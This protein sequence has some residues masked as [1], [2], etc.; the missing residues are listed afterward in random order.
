[1]FKTH[2]ANPKCPN[3]Q[4]DLF[5]YATSRTGN[6]PITYCS[7]TCEAEVKYDKRFDIRFK[8]S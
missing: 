2:C 8:Q 7:K 4:K 6:L 3:P 5:V 1:M